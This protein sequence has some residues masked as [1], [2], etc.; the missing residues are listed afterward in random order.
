MV[1]RL[2]RPALDID[3]GNGAGH[4]VEAGREYQIVEFIV[5]ATGAQAMWQNLF[6]R[7][8]LDVDQLDVGTIVGG[9]VIRIDADALRADRMVVRLQ[10]SGDRRIL[11]DLGDLL[12]N[13]IG[14]SVVGGL[15][16]GDIVVGRSEGQ[17]ALGPSCTVTRA[18]LLFGF[19]ECAFLG[20][21]LENTVAHFLARLAADFGVVV[22]KRLPL[23][24]RQLGIARRHAEVRGS[25]KH[26][27]LAG[28][29]GNKR[30]RL[31]RRR[32]GADHGD[33]LAGE[34]HLLMRP[35]SG[36]I[37][38]ALEIGEA[39]EIG[40]AGVGQ[41]TG[42]EHHELRGHGLSVRCGHRPGVGSLV[43]HRTIDPCVKLDIGPQVEAIGHV[44]GVTQNLGLRRVAFAPVPFLLQLI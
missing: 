25:L 43:E 19:I 24:R 2:A 32:T 34:I 26:E 9:V 11:D 16:D 6:D 3:L 17:A 7:V 44:V 37:D 36:V 33:T 30:D 42:G 35:V 41:T 13:E 14:G 29:L 12:A 23:F 22:A 1:Q 28:L 27:Q 20:K 21:L 18:P 8:C 31:D 5:L 4:G 15:V 40:H 10:Q 38:V 39:L